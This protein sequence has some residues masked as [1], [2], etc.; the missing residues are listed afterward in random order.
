MVDGRRRCRPG[1]LAAVLGLGLA[2]SA[3]LAAPGDPDPTFNRRG[4]VTTAF[5]TG[6]AS[7]SAIAMQDDQ[8]VLVGGRAEQ[9]DHFGT[10]FALTRY[11]PNGQLDPDFDG[12]GRLTFGIGP[13]SAI[14]A[15]VLQEDGRI[16][17]AG[18]T[19]DHMSNYSFAVA[20]FLTSGAPD[21]E[22]GSGG[23]VVIDFGPASEH[24][25][26]VALDGDRIVVA[27]IAYN[28]SNYDFGVVRLLADG[29][30]DLSFDGDGRRTI[31]LFG[32]E[33][34]VYA[35]AVQDD[36]KLL[37]GG[38]GNVGI[39]GHMTLVRLQEEGANDPEFDEDGIAVLEVGIGSRVQAIAVLGD[40]RILVGGLTV[41]PVGTFWQQDFVVAR[42]GSEGAPDPGFGE[43]DG[44][45]T[46]AIG[47]ANDILQA[48][49]IQSDGKILA[50]GHTSTRR[51]ADFALVRY[52]SDG[53]LDAG[54]GRG[55]MRTLNIGRAGRRGKSI[56][57]AYAIALQADGRSLLAGVT[58]TG[59][60]PRRRRESFAVTRHLP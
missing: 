54:F 3:A 60:T 32:A 1:I 37:I 50:A 15:V 57:L 48:L 25:R 18:W 27:G 24:A 20:R 55:G 29:T 34:D 8:K 49:A 59:S 44:Y 56:D 9:A 26:T 35:L 23:S 30:P 10:E 11:L 5:A 53:T 21:P 43:G 41:I 4:I 58:N 2:C 16:V 46:T 51:D 19:G 22:F 12:D 17:A 28:G 13:E 38:T 39:E 40:D 31:D 47:E 33:D 42:F 45:V 52:A 6:S 36:R 14:A 7:A